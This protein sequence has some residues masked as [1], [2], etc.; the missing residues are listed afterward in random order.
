MLEAVGIDPDTAGDRRP[1]RVLRRPVPAHQHRPGPDGRSRPAHLR[2]A[3]LRPRRLGPG[4][5]PQPAGRP[6]GQVR[7]HHGVHRPRPGRGQERERPGGGDVPRASW[8]EI[9]GSDDLYRSAAHPY[10][11]A[12]LASIPEPDPDLR[13]RPHGPGRRAALAA[14]PAVGLP[15]PHPVPLRPAA[16]RRAG[17]A[18]ARHRRPAT[19]WPATSRWSLCRRADGSGVAGG[20]AADGA[21]P[22]APHRRPTPAAI[23]SEPEPPPGD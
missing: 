5:D 8:C 14:Q 17:T 21:P 20:G 22:P 2:R 10:T 7:P 18:A 6:Q 11:E 3:G 16:L 23:R 19:R 9:A 15:V 1:G 4:P 12:L 13:T